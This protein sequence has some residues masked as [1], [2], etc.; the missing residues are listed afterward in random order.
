MKIGLFGGSFNPI[1]KGHVTALCAFV[2]ECALDRVLIIPSFLPPHKKLPLEWASFEKR[3]DMVRLA[4]EGIDFGDC[5]AVV[6]D[7]EKRLYDMTGERSY[8]RLTLEKLK[9]ETAGEYYLFVG[10]DMFTT[11]ESWRDA[12]YI[13]KNAVIAPMARDGAEGIDEFKKIYERKYGAEIEVINA[14]HLTV[15]ST[16]VRSSVK[17]GGAPLVDGKVLKY[18]DS[19]KLYMERLDRKELEESLRA[20]LSPERYSH[21]LE[22]EKKALY[23][24]DALCPDF[25][26][27]VSRAALLHDITKPKTLEEQIALADSL[28]IHLDEN[29]L[30]SPQTLHAKTGAG[31][32]RTVLGEE[33]VADII[34]THTTGAP[35]MSIWQMIV[36]IS[37][38]IEDTRHHDACIKERTLFEKS[39]KNATTFQEKVSSLRQSVYRILQG[40]VAHLEEKK[41]FIHPLTL[42][43]LDYYR[44]EI[45]E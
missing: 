9:K 26:E 45:K 30:A 32:V 5:E 28:N 2:R 19:H 39:L 24:A 7:I 37:D 29:D 11:L 14:P 8:T 43:A 3:C 23:I 17:N 27:V 13:F 33:D 38:Y 1:H 42:E 25:K 22:V 40:T 20:T 44:A 36:F 31:Y 18:I 41:S 35:N 4:I 6:S 10:T 21:T 34:L 15:S 12:E 16:E